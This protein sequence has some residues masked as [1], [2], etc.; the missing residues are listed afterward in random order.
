MIENLM[1]VLF[2]KE[3]IL[4]IDHHTRYTHDFILILQVLKMTNVIYMGGDIRIGCG[5]PLDS[6]HGAYGL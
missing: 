3:N 6:H 1:K 2:P 4:V 5:D